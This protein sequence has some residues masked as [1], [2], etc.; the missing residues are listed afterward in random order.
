MDKLAKRK[1]IASARYFKNKGEI[2]MWRS[3]WHEGKPYDYHLYEEDGVSEVYIYQVKKVNGKY[4]VDT[5]T[6]LHIHT[7]NQ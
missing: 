6:T 5:S 7:F 3:V 2:D 1:A 4:K